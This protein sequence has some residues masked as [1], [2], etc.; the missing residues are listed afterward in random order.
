MML[1]HTPGQSADGKIGEGEK[2]QQ[3]N[4][5]ANGRD[6]EAVVGPTGSA[7][8]CFGPWPLLGVWGAAGLGCDEG[9][10]LGLLVVFGL[11]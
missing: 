4:D 10:V 9:L 7:F 8:A 1:Y 3:Q 11:V 2:H 5:Q 6:G